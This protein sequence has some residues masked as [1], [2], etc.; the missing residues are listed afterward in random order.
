MSRKVVVGEVSGAFGVRG[1]VK[2]QSHTSPP[3]NILKYSPWFM[4]EGGREQSFKV[5]EGQLHGNAVVAQLE[6]IA[7]RD[8]ASLLRKRSILVSREGFDP[9]E[10][11]EYYWADL[12]GL[13]V[14]TVVGLSL[15]TVTNMIETGANDVMQVRGERERL[16]PFVVGE[17]V[18]D[19]R[20][21]EGLVI[22]DWDPD[23]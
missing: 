18:K 15:G 1:W 10:P 6:G 11:G 7:D 3:E 4:E 13:E 2:V 22:V 5:I 14:R 19:V 20:T 16:I 21:G 17:F 8:Q 23:F 9:L 12:V